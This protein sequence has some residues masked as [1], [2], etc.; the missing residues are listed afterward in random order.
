MYP[1][2]R[3]YK[4]AQETFTSDLQR[5]RRGYTTFYGKGFVDP[6]AGDSLYT[7]PGEDSAAFL[8]AQRSYPNYVSSQADYWVAE[9]DRPSLWAGAVYTTDMRYAFNVTRFM[10]D[11]GQF[12]VYL[13]MAG[14]KVPSIYGPSADEPWM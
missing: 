10:L 11:R 1:G 6:A 13:R 2:T 7:P 9:W 14:G 3:G 4:V 12:S 5:A 8:T